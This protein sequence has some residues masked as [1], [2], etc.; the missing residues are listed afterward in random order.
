MWRHAIG[1]NIRQ[2][3]PQLIYLSNQGAQKGGFSNIGMLWQEEM[4]IDNVE[5]LMMK[6]LNEIQPFYNMLHAFVK[7]IL[8]KRFAFKS[9]FNMPAH[10]LG[11]NANWHH[12]LGD[13]VEPDGWRVD[14][15]LAAR[16]W[17]SH[18]VVK[19]IEDFYTSLG[20][21]RLSNEFWEKS[22]IE[23]KSSEF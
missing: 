20:L 22:Y 6:L 4:E 10:L 11:W 14:E 13:Y 1:P 3:F 23:G 16:Q 5:D 18:E 7:S 12:L 19:R 8:E 15:K 2:L 21:S 9:K 17:S